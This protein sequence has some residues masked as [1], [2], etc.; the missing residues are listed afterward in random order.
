MI[1]VSLSGRNALSNQNPYMKTSNLALRNSL[2]LLSFILLSI[3]ACDREDN[4]LLDP[5]TVLEFS[6]DTLTFDTVFTARGSATRILKIYNPNNRPVLIDRIAVGEGS[7]SSFRFNI[8]GVP[9]NE[10]EDIEIAANDS[11]YIFGEV[12]VDPDADLMSSPFVI[13]DE[14]IITL[15]GTPRTVVLEAFGQNANYLP[16]VNGVNTIFGL[17]CQGGEVVWDDP[18]PYVIF[19]ILVIEDCTLR[20]PAGT[21]VYIHGGLQRTFVQDPDNPQDSVRIFFNDGRLIIGPNSRLIVEG[22][23]DEPVIIQGDRLED[24]FSETPGQWFGIVISAGSRG[25]VIEHAEI[26]NGIFGVAV[27]SAAELTTKNT[28]YANTTSSGL[29]GI[30]SQVTAENCLFSNNA[31]GSVNILYGGNYDFTYCTLA[32]Y[33]VD[34]S[35]LSLSNVLCID[36]LCQEVALNPLSARFTNCIIAGS[37]DDELNFLASEDVAFNYTFDH[38]IVRVDDLLDDDQFPEF[39]DNC[40]EC[41]NVELGDALF[42]NPAGLDFH[43]DT[44][45]VAERRAIPIPSIPLDLDG[46]QRDGAEPDL[47]AYEYVE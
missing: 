33:G 47:G 44:L 39:F 42:V 3:W 28:I 18:K 32:S 40:N 15:N 14:M 6:T 35:A 27:D 34:A 41:L 36:P 22:T 8:D 1:S 45:S 46:V 37:R 9:G 12:T 16:V 31:N 13:Y 29:I 19:G 43:L 2:F 7:S 10:R 38:C 26:K 20:I 25:N 11:L 21:N 17:G 4:F 5:D 30:H 23:Q 24:S